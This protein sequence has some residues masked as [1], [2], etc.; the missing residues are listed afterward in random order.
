MKPTR[1][2]W[3]ILAFCAALAVLDSFLAQKAWGVW[4]IILFAWSL[5]VIFER[6]LVAFTKTDIT[7]VFETPLQF[8]KTTTIHYAFTNNNPFPL[9]ISFQERFSPLLSVETSAFRCDCAQ[10]SQSVFS[11]TVKPLTIGKVDFT[12]IKLLIK[13]RLSLF[14]WSR[15]LP[16]SESHNVKPAVTPTH[17]VQA[18][19]LGKLRRE[20]AHALCLIINAGTHSQLAHQSMTRYAGYVD[21]AY[22]MAATAVHAHYTVHI[23]VYDNAPLYSGLHLRELRHLGDFVNFLHR[24]RSTIQPSNHYVPVEFLSRLTGPASLFWYTDIDES[25]K[26]TALY[27]AMAQMKARHT[28]TLFNHRDQET[29]FLHER[30]QTHQ[31]DPVYIYSTLSHLDRQRKAALLHTGLGIHCVSSL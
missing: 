25:D 30:L 24:P 4:S 22:Q 9:R 6:I 27:S 12:D 16:L 29:A 15:S 5:L 17:R 19:L 11:A 14:W 10:Q 28:I 26:Q 8:G 31:S 23:V 20:G 13:G 1:F 7:R 21:H 18:T 3:G 2:S